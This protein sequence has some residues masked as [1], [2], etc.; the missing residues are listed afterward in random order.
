MCCNMKCSF[1]YLIFTVLLL[2]LGSCGRPPEDLSVFP[3][4]S[5][6]DHPDIASY[7]YVGKVG[8]KISSASAIDLAVSGWGPDAG[9]AAIDNLRKSVAA[10]VRPGVHVIRLKWNIEGRKVVSYALADDEYVLYDDVATY[11]LR[12][13][14]HPAPGLVMNSDA[15]KTCACFH[16]ADTL[17]SVLGYPVASYQICFLT[18]FNDNGVVCDRDSDIEIF[19]AA[20]WNV[21]AEVDV[22][23]GDIHVSDFQEIAWNW[24]VVSPFSTAS[25]HNSIV[26]RP[27]SQSG[28]VADRPAPAGSA[29]QTFLACGRRGSIPC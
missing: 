22:V 19:N 9:N 23:S 1:K 4:T 16:A 11:Y 21:H 29:S 17:F 24:S 14:E 5:C 20:G 26:I 13:C 2:L 3:W 28:A 8:D 6:L 18:E 12:S 27:D 25:G 15:G 7:K 10:V